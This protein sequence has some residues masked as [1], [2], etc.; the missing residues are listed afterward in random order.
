MNDL[1]GIENLT[2]PETSR[3]RRDVAR[4]FAQWHLGDPAWADQ[5]LAA[6][7]NPAATAARLHRE[8]GTT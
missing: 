3:E 5:I 2:D 6:F 4:E 7:A 1:G 8:Q